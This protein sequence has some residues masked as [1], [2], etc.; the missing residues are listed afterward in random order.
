MA[1]TLTIARIL[2]IVP[3]VALFLANS[4]WNMTAALGVF[5]IA[6]ATDFLDGWVARA[7]DEVSRLGAA[8]D[9]L[10]DKL[11]ITAALMLLVRNGVIHGPHVLAALAIILR[12]MLV[13]GLREATGGQLPGLAVTRLAKWKT[14]C[15]LG[16]CALLI[17]AAPTGPI[18]MPAA[19]WALA[20]LWIACALTLWTGGFYVVAAVRALSD[21]PAI[22]S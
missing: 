22:R 9:P 11:I 17:A 13:S 2:L 18:G 10:A 5:V 3:F 15:Q 21:A 20:A 1:N 8:L 19:T 7:R 4:P 6:A 14:A 12:E 16:A